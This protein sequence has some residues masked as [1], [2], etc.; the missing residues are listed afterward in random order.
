MFSID[1]IEIKAPLALSWSSLKNICQYHTVS[2]ELIVDLSVK[3]LHKLGHPVM[4]ML[5][6]FWRSKL[7]M[8]ACSC[9]LKKRIRPCLM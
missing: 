2:Q 3:Y 9:F 5:L 7:K 1:V 8:V 4:F 6:L